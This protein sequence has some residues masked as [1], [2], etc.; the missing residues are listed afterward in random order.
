MGTIVRKIACRCT[1]GTDLRRSQGLSLKRS[2]GRAFKPAVAPSHVLD[3]H[4]Y[5]AAAAKTDD[6]ESQEK[7]SGQARLE[8]LGYQQ[9]LSR[10]FGLLSSAASSFA[11]TSYMMSLTGEQSG[12]AVP[13]VF[14]NRMSCP[15]PDSMAASPADIAL[16]HAGSL[17]GAY[18]TGGSVPAL[19]GW[20]I[21][22]IFNF[23]VVLSMAE[24]SSAYPMAGG[25]YF[26]Y[27]AR[28]CLC[29]RNSSCC[30]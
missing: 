18:V 7:D 27:F 19:W 3:S 9:L 2:E 24:L 28:G 6:P 29:V 30:V 17:P 14:D 5:S 22:A 11:V 26:W 16:H 13:D 1:G 12:A 21:V 15:V 25:P 8:A 23:A 20:L 4:L 10:R